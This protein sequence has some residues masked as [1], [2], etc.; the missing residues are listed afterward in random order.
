MALRP[1]PAPRCNTNNKS[2]AAFYQANAAGLS[3]DP[4]LRAMSGFPAWAA[5][6]TSLWVDSAG[7]AIALI[8]EDDTTLT[9]DIPPGVVVVLTRPIKSI[10]E[11]ASGDVN[12]LFEWF[13][14][15]GSPHW[16]P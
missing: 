16:N 12:A 8:D 6:K 14:P 13:D 5:Q 2:D 11:S 9:L 1:I 15:N 7:A 4:D 3:S 10:D